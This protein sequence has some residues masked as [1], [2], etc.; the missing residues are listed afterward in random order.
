MSRRPLLHV[1]SQM[2]IICFRDS[3]GGK[4]GGL[5]AAATLHDLYKVSFLTL[6]QYAKPHIDI[7]LSFSKNSCHKGHSWNCFI[8]KSFHFFSW[9]SGILVSSQNP[10]F[11]CLGYIIDFFHIFYAIHQK[12]TT[13]TKSTRATHYCSLESESLCRAS[14]FSKQR[15][16]FCVRWICSTHVD[17]VGL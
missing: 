4:E 10:F 2:R 5:N 16:M 17:L 9:C 3:K 15:E 6:W 1:F 12:H 8:V 7:S 14:Y 13:T 11:L